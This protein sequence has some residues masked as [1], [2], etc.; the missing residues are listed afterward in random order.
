MGAGLVATPT[1]PP[2][3]GQVTMTI[4]AQTPPPSSTTWMY[5]ISVPG[6]CTGTVNTTG[7]APSSAVIMTP[8]PGIYTIGALSQIPFGPPLTLSTNVAVAPPTSVRTIAGR[9]VP[10][11]NG[12]SVDVVDQIM[13]SSNTP[14]G[15]MINALAQER[16]RGYVSPYMVGPLPNW[17]PDVPNS[18]FSQWGGAI[19]DLCYLNLS[20]GIWNTIPI[21][22][23]IATY[24]QDLQLVT[25]YACTSG[26]IYTLTITLNSLNWTWT[27]VSATQF[28]VN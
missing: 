1:S 26:P 17:T 21:G 2:T 15:T 3:G 27:K 7:G 20:P 6:K 24:I 28:T 5:G 9:G 16:I 8:Q 12:T 13:Q 19:H 10:T 11:P 14:S 22:G 18:N 4:V 23:T 25:S